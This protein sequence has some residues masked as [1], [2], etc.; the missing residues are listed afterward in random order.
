MLISRIS[1]LGIAKG[2]SK[3]KL[4]AEKDRLAKTVKEKFRGY[5]PV[6]LYFDAKTNVVGEGVKE[7]QITIIAWN[8]NEE[9]PSKLG[10]AVPSAQSI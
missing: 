5:R 9:V 3:K 4:N 10:Y 7:H 6:A 2:V 8:E 1:G